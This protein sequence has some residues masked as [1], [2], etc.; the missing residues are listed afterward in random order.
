MTDDYSNDRHTTGRLRVGE[1]ATGEIE[2]R[3]DVDWIK[4]RLQPG[5]TYRID[6]E[7]AHS[8]AGTLYDPEILGIYDAAATLLPDTADDD[9]GTRFNSRLVFTA[10]E[11]GDYYIAIGARG[12]N[13]GTYKLLLDE[14]GAD[15]LP[16]GRAGALRIG[17]PATGEIELPG[18]RDRFE[19]ALKAGR[20]YHVEIDGAILAGRQVNG[21][22]YE[23]S[24]AGGNPVSGITRDGGERLFF[25]PP[26]DGIYTIEVGAA[27]NLVNNTGL[28][29]LS[30]R[31][32]TRVDDHTAGGGSVLPVG[33]AVA[34][35]IERPGDRDWFA[36]TLEAGAL[37]QVEVRGRDSGGGTLAD[38]LLR[39]LYEDT[40]N[41]RPG[42]RVG[43]SSDDN[44]GAGQDSLLLFRAPEAGVWHLAVASRFTGSGTYTVSVKEIHQ[45]G[46][47]A[48]AAGAISVGGSVIGALDGNTGE[49]WYAVD[50]E[51]GVD[52]R[53]EVR[54]NTS[55]AHGGTLYNP[56]LTVYDAAGEAV[57]SAVAGDGTGKLGHNAA[58]EFRVYESGAYYVG[59][60]GGGR[61]GSY[62]LYANR[63]TDEY[64]TSILTGGRV[65]VG[66]PVAADIGEPRDR[67]WLAVD[68]E[69]GRAYRVDLEGA[70]TGRGTL[71]DPY[72]LGVY[73]NRALLPG[74]T[75]DD[76]GEGLNSRAEFLAPETG[77]YYIAAGAYGARTGSYRV[78]VREVADDHPASPGTAAVVTVDDSVTGTV[79][80]GGDTDWFAVSLAAGEEY[81]IDL[82]GWR[83]DRGTLEDPLLVGIYDSDGELI[84]GTTDDDSGAGYNARLDF[85][86]PYS[87]VYYI[88][89][90]A[91][92]DHTGTYT[93]EVMAVL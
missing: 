78:S 38:P 1:S 51:Q 37:Y 86:A 13:G 55:G 84:D 54:G 77:A 43:D 60:D 61:W 29:A 75:D 19:V 18:D 32:V 28:Y 15:D 25:R 70:P 16:A 30:V 21:R 83:T 59:I 50:L 62:T 11:Y 2:T 27:S 56:N 81:R 7:G 45:P 14:V 23:L 36:L 10:E 49:A 6:L 87:G 3:G 65:A 48:D 17:A 69:G 39:G 40:G 4:V 9:G 80:Y 73:F 33:G 91:Y 85:E 8:G 82:E 76:G 89:A 52:Y 24:D 57:H 20:T 35:V 22:L 79:D 34:G 68:L 5:T 41:G 47:D 44:S 63:L 64:P 12:G 72:L 88:A 90:G 66:A 42:R 74:T 46:A 71:T 31:D 93:L 92:E 58:L 53:V 67:D 26:A